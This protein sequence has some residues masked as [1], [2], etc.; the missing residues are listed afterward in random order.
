MED[1]DD[2]SVPEDP[3]A[4]EGE[5]K[6]AKSAPPSN[7][8]LPPTNSQRKRTRRSTKSAATGITSANNGRTEPQANGNQETKVKEGEKSSA[9][10]TLAAS[11]SMK[12]SFINAVTPETHD[13]CYRNS[14]TGIIELS[15]DDCTCKTESPRVLPGQPQIIRLTEPRHICKLPACAVLAFKDLQT[16]QVAH[17]HDITQLQTAI[18]Q[19]R[20]P[21]EPPFLDITG[22]SMLPQSTPSE[23]IQGDVRKWLN[24]GSVQSGVNEAGYMHEF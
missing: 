6:P 7:I 11:V 24:R 8:D 4:P 19:I 1:D 12:P 17:A 9:I 13:R 16:Q 21:P 22:D 2:E 15:V 3:Y 23:S 20:A 5:V 18:A 14:T 10:A